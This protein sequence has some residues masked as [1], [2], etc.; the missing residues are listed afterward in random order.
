[1][2]IGAMNHPMRDFVSEIEWIGKNNFEFV[3]LTY[4]AP[5]NKDF[6]AEKIKEALAKYGLGVVGHSS[7]S[8]PAIYP[9]RQ[10]REIIAEELKKT[11]DS[12][13]LVG[14]KRM[15]IHPFY[16]APNLS[17]KEVFNANIE[18]LKEIFNYCQSIGLE[19]MLENY[20][21]PFD[22]PEQF[23]N[24][25][26]EI[27]DLNIHL[28]IGHCN[29]EGDAHRIIERFFQ[30]FGKKIVHM[31]MHDNDGNSDEHLPLGCGCGDIKWSQIIKTIKDFG[32][33]ETIT[34]EVFC[35]DL[36]FLLLSR[37]KLQKMWNEVE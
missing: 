11:A 6:N 20:L 7:P 19:L 35:E 4:E 23:E 27:P 21:S 37:D 33:D 24:I 34:L 12:F 10:V 32:Y 15:N 22:T 26:N 16:N 18:V 5:K 28:D 31:H 1:M 17:A 29:L 8:L 13:R 14:A 2:K 3:D 30:K 25:L 36:D 9:I